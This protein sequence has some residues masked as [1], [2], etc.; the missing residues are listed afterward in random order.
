MDDL[1]FDEEQLQIL[2]EIGVT[3]YDAVAFFKHRSDG[4]TNNTFAYVDPVVRGETYKRTREVLWAFDAVW[5]SSSKRIVVLNFIRPFRGPLH[6]MMRRYRYVE[7]GMV[8]GKAEDEEVVEQA[9]QNYK[10]CKSPIC[11][12]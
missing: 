8:I 3:M 2:G 1:W 5:G 11:L 7:D 9:R 12:V 6:M 10:L 4:E